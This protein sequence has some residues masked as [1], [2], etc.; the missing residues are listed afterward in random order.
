MKKRLLF[1]L[2]A[3]VLLAGCGQQSSPSSGHSPSASPS[4]VNQGHIPSR[5]QIPKINVDA[6]VEQVGLDSQ[7]RM[8]VPKV[9]ADVAWYDLGPKPGQAGDAAI[10]GHLDWT[11]GPAV[12]WHLSDLKVGDSIQVLSADGTKLE[13]RVALV[14]SVAYNSTP[15]HV[16]DTS[17]NPQLTLITCAGTWDKQHGTYTNRLVINADPVNASK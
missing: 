6:P 12:F 14:R 10:A 7:G 8:G 5:L 9:A 3:L 2:S 11:T 16:F 17:G 4:P 1:G 15:P 13:Y